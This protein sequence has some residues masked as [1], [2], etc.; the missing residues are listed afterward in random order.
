M[1]CLLHW[2]RYTLLYVHDSAVTKTCVKRGSNRCQRAPICLLL[3]LQ[4]SSPFKHCATSAKIFLSSVEWLETQ[5]QVF[6]VPQNR[7]NS[8][9]INQNFL[10]FHVPQNN[11]FSEN[12]NQLPAR[13]A[14]Y[15]SSCSRNNVCYNTTVYMN[16][17]DQASHGKTSLEILYHNLG[18]FF[19]VLT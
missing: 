8:N 9:R 15:S 3:I 1:Q 12:G 16:T 7:W 11:F 5:F 4:R 13:L 17:T 10:L 19:P 6:S 2:V 18:S 14:Q